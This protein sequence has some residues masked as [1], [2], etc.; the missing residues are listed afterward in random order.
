MLVG[1]DL[2]P[3]RVDKELGSGAMGTVYRAKHKDNGERVAVKLM[4]PALGTSEQA[5]LRFIRELDILKQLNHPNIVRYK[6]SGR[7]H[8]SPFF[9]MEYVEG[10]S[11]DHVMAR[12]DRVTWEEIVEF[13][14]QLCEALQ[15]SH[16]KG[17]IH[18]DMKPSN[19]MVLRDGTVKL[20]DFGIAKDT[21][22]TALTAAN[23]T[24]GTAAYMSPEQCRGARDI[25]FKSDLY[26]LG[27]ML[28]ELLTGRKPFTAD[29]AMEMFLK[30]ANAPFAPPSQWVPECPT[31]LN[32]IICQ[33]MEKKPEQRPQSAATVAEALK[34]VKEKMATQQSA[35]LDA[36]KKRRIDRT[37]TDIALDE[38]DRDA[39]RAMLGK[40]KRKKKAQP[41]YTR[42]WFTIAA[43]AAIAVTVI[44]VGYFVFLRAATAETLFAEAQA[45]MKSGDDE[46]RDEARKGPVA[47]FLRAYPNHEKAPQVQAW[48]DEVDR[49]MREKQMFNRRNRNIIADSEPEKDA[50]LALDS[51]DLGKLD[52]AARLWLHIAELKDAKDPDVRAW[53]LVGAK[54]YKDLQDV[55]NTYDGLKVALQSEKILKQKHEPKSIHEER[56][57]QAVRE[58]IAEQWDKAR[59][60]WELLKKRTESEPDERRW[61]LLAVKRLRE[62][63]KD[64]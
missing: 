33:L 10:D 58:E 44:I 24:V 40:K 46:K 50:R 34:Q 31:W 49:E 2:G 63:K 17:I 36:V 8:G 25:T 32:T 57:I 64:K 3:Y 53:G 59:D 9:I 27:V 21:D 26:S 39:A 20:T 16:D 1:K 62:L 56:A 18:R 41:F 15:H 51:E 4:S 37:S 19:V 61:Y 54:Y 22:V 52:A 42:G 7:F 14:M 47:E 38:S 28:Y 12:R 30:H 60:E 6:G 55:A 43:L 13:G 11:L 29:T 23:S 45:L 5:R 35:A 48:A